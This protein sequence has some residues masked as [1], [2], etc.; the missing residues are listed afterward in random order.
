LC[1]KCG[2]NFNVNGVEQDGWYMPPTLPT[3]PNCSE[4]ECKWITRS[5]DLPGVVH[6]R[7]QTY[8]QHADPIVE[9]FEQRDRL[10]KLTPYKGFDQV[11]AMIEQ[12]RDFLRSNIRDGTNHGRR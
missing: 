1:K 8:H 2:G 4:E 3:S 7:L 10:L 5:D 6:T 11:P 9:Y 12:V